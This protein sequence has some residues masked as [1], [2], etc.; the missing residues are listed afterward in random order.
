V[1]LE[2]RQTLYVVEVAGKTLLIGAGDRQVSVLAELD[3]AEVAKAVAAAPPPRPFA[4]VLRR[5]ARR[6]QPG[7]AA[8]AD[9]DRAAT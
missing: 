2:P 6:A 9:E 4:D 3:A 5:L 8:P 7:A 1:P